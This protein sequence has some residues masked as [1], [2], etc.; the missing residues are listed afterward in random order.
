LVGIKVGSINQSAATGAVDGRP[1]STVGGLVGINAALSDPAV[2]TITQSY[3]GG[4]VTGGK[5]SIV[6]G[7]V[8]QNGGVI[9]QTYAVGLVA[10]GTGGTAGGLVG[11]GNVTAQAPSGYV[12]ATA[13]GTVSTSYFDTQPTGQQTSVGGSGQITSQLVNVLPSGFSNPFAPGSS[14]YP[15]IPGLPTI[16]ASASALPPAV[17]RRRR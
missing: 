9:T 11:Q 17:A 3:A 1:G 13:A 5:S 14:D 4:P 8:G 6:G 2:G 16:L 12:F 15:T 7:L 10:T